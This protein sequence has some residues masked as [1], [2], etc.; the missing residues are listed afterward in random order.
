MG[1]DII[2]PYSCLQEIYRANVSVRRA[3]QVGDVLKRVLWNAWNTGEH[4]CA[5]MNI[6]EAKE[7]YVVGSKPK[8][9]TWTKNN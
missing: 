1:G 2:I 9:D 7:V 5:F 8:S 4:A 3:D 6:D